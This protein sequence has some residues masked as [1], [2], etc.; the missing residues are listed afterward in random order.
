MSIDGSEWRRVR[1]VVLEAADNG[2]RTKFLNGPPQEQLRQLVADHGAERVIEWVAA[3]PAG[4]G[5]PR[6]VE[7]LAD[8]P[9]QPDEDLIEQLRQRPEAET[10]AGVDAPPVVE[11][12]R[13][14][15]F[16]GHD[17]D[18]DPAA[19]AVAAAR[20]ALRNRPAAPVDGTLVDGGAH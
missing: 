7:W 8:R 11:V 16:T 18:G 20:E 3:S 13:L 14:R 15:E 4:L 2:G 19:P 17:Y 9:H 10:I 12:P 5:V 1:A 6:L